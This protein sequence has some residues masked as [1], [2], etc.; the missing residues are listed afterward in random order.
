MVGSIFVFKEAKLLDLQR[1]QLYMCI[2]FITIVVYFRP[3]NAPSCRSPIIIIYCILS[4]QCCDIG[5]K[6][7]FSSADA[8][9]KFMLQDGVLYF[10]AACLQV[11]MVTFI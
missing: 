9:A 6:I 11:V 5:Q 10:S 1:S 2:L 4:C 7:I 3:L 8:N